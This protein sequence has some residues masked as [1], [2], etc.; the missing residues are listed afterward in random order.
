MELVGKSIKIHLTTPLIAVGTNHNIHTIQGKV[1]D[2][3]SGG[4][5]IE[6]RQWSHPKRVTSIRTKP[7]LFHLIKSISLE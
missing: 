6:F 3:G 4:F 7:S 2:K 1:L 5:L